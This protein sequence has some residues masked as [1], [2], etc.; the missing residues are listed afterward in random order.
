MRELDD[1]HAPGG[2]VRTDAPCDP[3]RALRALSPG[4][5]IL[6]R[7]FALAF[8]A[9][10]A[11]ACGSAPTPVPTPIPPDVVPSEGVLIVEV[12][13]VGQ[14]DGIII[15][16]PA[17]KSVL[18]D[19]GDRPGWRPILAQLEAH[20]ITEL[21]LAIISHPHA[22]HIGGMQ[23]V[24]EKVPTKLFLDPGFDYASGIYARLLE[25]LEKTDTRIVIARAGRSIDIG[26]GATIEILL[27][28]EPMLTGTRS[29]AN[30]NSVVFKLVYGTTTMLFTGDAEAPTERRLLE[31]P[32]ALASD[33]LKV[34]HHGSNHS[35]E[36]AFLAAVRP[37]IAVISC[38]VDN[39]FDHPGQ[40]TLGRLERAGV[41][42]LRTDLLGTITL[43]SD[44]ARWTVA[45]A[46][47][48]A[49]PPPLRTDK[50]P[51]A[52]DGDDPGDTEYKPVRIEPL[53]QV[54]RTDR[55]ERVDPP[56]G[57]GKVGA[58]PTP[59]GMLDINSATVEQLRTV[60]G[61]GPAKA[62]AIIAYRG[63]HGPFVRIEDLEN[64]PGIGAKTRQRLAE[65][66]AVFPVKP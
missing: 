61:I 55:T 33:I 4:F 20:G 29:D 60:E 35:T 18:L 3:P 47:K 10:A 58:P 37:R 2:S 26:G 5:T 51:P 66:F 9:S 6:A 13:D 56:D 45:V 12:V 62:A 25:L 28:R 14:G 65:K 64:V 53:R 59:V 15:R 39:K 50:A 36:D 32:A 42:I 21:D 16:S 1:D 54:D 30:S 19:A 40:S 22:D 27:P 24:L 48:V 49:R 63:E 8:V 57:A 52:D 44:G 34:A 41:Q 43:T 46:N 38:G 11:S 31:D 23:K 17:G 7:A